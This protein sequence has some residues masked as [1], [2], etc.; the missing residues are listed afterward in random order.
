MSYFI[1][2]GKAVMVQ[3][4][5]LVRKNP[6][7]SPESR[8]GPAYKCL[9]LGTKI[10][11]GQGE[12]VFIQVSQRRRGPQTKLFKMSVVC[13]WLTYSPYSLF[14]VAF[15]NT[16]RS[17]FRL[18]LLWEL[19]VYDR[20]ETSSGAVFERV[21][22]R[23]WGEESIWSSMFRSNS[24]NS[25]NSFDRLQKWTKERVSALVK[26]WWTD[27]SSLRLVGQYS[28]FCS[29][30]DRLNTFFELRAQ[31]KWF[32][33]RCSL[34]RAGTEGIFGAAFASSS[35]GVCRLKKSFSERCSS[36]ETGWPTGGRCATPCPAA[37][38]ITPLCTT[39][40]SRIERPTIYQLGGI[41]KQVHR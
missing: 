15:E 25:L 34:W 30:N 35:T 5:I 7:E 8:W 41:D 12:C 1:A 11:S 40:L 29:L 17:V 3:H 39:C 19:H 32:L 33:F 24:A 13:D 10:H 21:P 14:W 22:V 26:T 38:A 37:R 6:E 31:W 9:P 18:S 23:E 16:T 20:D 36:E 2:E 4:L 27:A 28:N